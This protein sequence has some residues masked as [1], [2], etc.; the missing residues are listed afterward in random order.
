MYKDYNNEDFLII[1]NSLKSDVGFGMNNDIDTCWFDINEETLTEE[2]KPTFII[3]E[4]SE[5]KEIL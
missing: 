5:L 2:Y 3:K 4:L 1:G